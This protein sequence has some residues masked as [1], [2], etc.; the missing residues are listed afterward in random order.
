M[1]PV[2]SAAINAGTNSSG[3]SSTDLY[4]A[5]IVEK[6]QNKKKRKSSAVSFDGTAEASD[7]K[8]K[9]S[10]SSSKTKK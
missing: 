6:A 4:Q 7:P 8:K 9:T 2:S 3:I 5:G 1:I 10:K